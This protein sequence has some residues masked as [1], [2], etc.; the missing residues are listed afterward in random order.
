MKKFSIV[1]SIF[2]LVQVCFTSV[3]S[4]AGDSTALLR[5]RLSRDLIYRDLIEKNVDVVANYPD[6]WVDV[7]VTEMQRQWI[8]MKAG[9]YILLETRML[10]ASA[11]LDSNLGMYHT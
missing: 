1:L 5:I 9:D 11:D 3:V 4:A 7:A 6:G 8:T 10:K 2:I